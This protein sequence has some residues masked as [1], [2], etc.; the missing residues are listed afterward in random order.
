VFPPPPPHSLAFPLVPLQTRAFDEL[1]EEHDRWL[2]WAAGR[3]SPLPRQTR[4]PGTNT[5]IPQPSR[6]PFKTR[7]FDPLP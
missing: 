6:C 2:G 5:F 1:W 4:S 3:R 7:A